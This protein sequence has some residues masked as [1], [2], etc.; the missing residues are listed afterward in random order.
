MNY[1]YKLVKFFIRY[2][3]KEN[4]LEWAGLFRFLG[5]DSR[6]FAIAEW[7]NLLKKSIHPDIIRSFFRILVDEKKIIIKNGIV[8]I[9]DEQQLQRDFEVVHSIIN[10]LSDLSIESHSKLLWSVPQGY[11]IPKKI[12]D[13]FDHLNSWIQQLIQ[14]TNDRLIF[15]APYYS[16]AG[17]RHFSLSLR[18]LISV[19]KEVKIDWILGEVHNE[20]NE[21]AINFL[22]QTFDPQRINI[23]LPK[24]LNERDLVIHAKVLISD[25]ER[26]YMGSANFSKG[27][28]ISQFEL[29]VTLSKSQVESL[30]K[31]IDYW[32]QSDFLVKLP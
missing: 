1:L 17:L 4:V 26:G 28:L 21:K 14:N 20:E 32:I 9:Q 18:T 23:Y 19:K 31:L 25:N 10:L 3:L 5:H 6:E 8:N 12:A 27:A 22:N 13:Q 11:Q 29:G 15:F 24:N 30:I 16:E 2:N 7:T